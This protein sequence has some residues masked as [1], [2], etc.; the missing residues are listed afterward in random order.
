[1]HPSFIVAEVTIF[2]EIR[3]RPGGLGASDHRIRITL[4]E[5]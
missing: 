3:R 1:M 2:S 5:N 4:S